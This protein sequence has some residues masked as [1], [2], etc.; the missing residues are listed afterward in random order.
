MKR[1]LYYFAWTIV[2][3]FVLYFGMQL[4]EQLN[5]MAQQTFEPAAL[6]VFIALF[7]VALGLLLRTPKFLLEAKE[8]KSRKFDWPI[9]AAIGLPSLFLVLMSFLPFMPFIIGWI[10]IPEIILIGGTTVPTVAGLVFGYVLLD[11]FNNRT[12]K[13]ATRT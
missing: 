6:R 10:A 13:E 8:N 3:G 11:S 1:F 7:P 2:L 4:Q 5:E 12:M 9:F